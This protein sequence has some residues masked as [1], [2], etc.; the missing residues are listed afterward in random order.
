MQSSNYASDAMRTAL[1]LPNARVIDVDGLGDIE[2]DG[3]PEET[4]L[5]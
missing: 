2:F 5:M 4:R 1:H 3:S